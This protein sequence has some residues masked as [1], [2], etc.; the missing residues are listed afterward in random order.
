MTVAF[1]L[2]R[3]E[4]KTE[5]SIFARI[6]YNGQKLKYYLPEKI[7]PQFW[8]KDTQSVYTDVNDPPTDQIDPPIIERKMMS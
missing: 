5:T 2:T 6:S 7:N 4:A 3:P 8:S 1:Y